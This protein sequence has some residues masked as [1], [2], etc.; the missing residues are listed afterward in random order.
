M[1]SIN[2]YQQKKVKKHIKRKENPSYHLTNIDLN[3]R[4]LIVGASGAGKTNALLH[5][6]YNSPNTFAKIVICSKGIEEPLYEFL[7]EEF[8]KKSLRGKLEF[9]SL[10]SMPTL[11][12]IADLKEDKDEE[13]LIVFD[14]LVNDIPK[15]DTKV[16]NYYIAGRKLG[17]TMVFISQSYFRV[18]KVVRN[19]LNYLLL[20]KLSS[21]RD[22][23]LVM[24][25]YALGITPE[26]LV[27]LHRDATREPMQFLK[28][29]I[30]T[31]DENKKFSKGFLDYYTCGCAEASE[32]EIEA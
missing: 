19:Q 11:E 16:K 21:A 23:R 9:H 24:S 26:E 8:Q 12:Q 27:E 13:W 31:G 7:K 5:Y 18:D 22:L 14:D 28:I 6:I 30:N 4:I 25:D 32:E 17:C 2:F 3:S 1:S 10:E 15:K 29:D 20:L